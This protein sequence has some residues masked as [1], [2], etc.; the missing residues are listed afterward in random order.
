[1]NELNKTLD[2]QYFGFNY[3]TRTLLQILNTNTAETCDHHQRKAN[4]PFIVVELLDISAANEQR[5]NDMYRHH[6]PLTFALMFQQ[7]TL[8]LKQ[9]LTFI[10]DNVD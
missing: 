9:R 4:K 3:A 2:K 10:K 5:V 8:S 6:S 1:M 7:Q